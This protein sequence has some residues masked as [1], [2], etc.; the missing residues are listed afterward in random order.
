MRVK[1][2]V[3]DVSA[4]D[5][6]EAKRFYQDIFGLDVLMDMGWIA[7]YGSA[8][9]AARYAGTS[10]IRPSRDVRNLSAS[11]SMT[12]SSFELVRSSV[13]EWPFVRPNIRQRDSRV[14]PRRDPRAGRSG[15]R[16]WC[17][18]LYQATNAST[19]ACACSRARADILACTSGCEKWLHRW[20]CRHSREVG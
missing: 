11:S 15:S 4:P 14:W 17:S 20:R 18:V 8:L 19:H 7:T 1:R 2:I 13:G 12:S 3:V 16:S 9:V 10:K 5:P 6:S